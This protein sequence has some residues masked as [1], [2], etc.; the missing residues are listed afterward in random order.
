[1]AAISVREHAAANSYTRR[2]TK[3]VGKKCRSSQRLSVM[4]A[5]TM[6]AKPINP[7]TSS[8]TTRAA[9]PSDRRNLSK[10]ARL[11]ER[12]YENCHFVRGFNDKTLLR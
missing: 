8:T 3:K 7:T 10:M 12:A 5:K 11:L 4:N 1:M 9:K 2:D 6:S